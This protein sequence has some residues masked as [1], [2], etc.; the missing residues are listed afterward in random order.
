MGWRL[1]E[2]GGGGGGLKYC[3]GCLNNEGAVGNE[4]GAELSDPGDALGI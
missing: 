3:E 2:E 1:N 4:P